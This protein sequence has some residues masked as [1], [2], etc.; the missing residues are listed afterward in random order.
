MRTFHRIAAIFLLAFI[1]AHLG[2]H[3]AAALGPKTF[4]AY[5][6]TARA[7]Y[8]HPV[9]EPVL[10]ALFFVQAFTGFNL[11]IGSFHRVVKR[12]FS[13]WLELIS[14]VVFVF[15]IAIHLSAIAVTRFYFEMQT[16][17]Y[18]V[19]ELFRKS[20][21]QPYII[22]FHFLGVVAIAIHAGIGLKFTFR[23]IG[24]EKEGDWAAIIMIMSGIIVAALAVAAYSGALYS[25][26]LN[27]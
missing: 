4:N 10:I 3:V 23:S 1:I 16:D 15:F 9:I 7:F 13:A 27:N 5:L 11:I 22:G 21:L 17:F 19:A 18:W 6:A 8:R 25:I 20:T 2:N 26:D 12:S 24:L 14:I